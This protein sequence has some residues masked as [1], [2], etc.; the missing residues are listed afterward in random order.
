MV[1]AENLV[2]L[3][4]TTLV[5]MQDSSLTC[6]SCELITFDL[7][8]LE[9]VALMPMKLSNLC[10]RLDNFLRPSMVYGTTRSTG[11]DTCLICDCDQLIQS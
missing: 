2:E 6:T 4:G 1:A 10:N 7:K 5:R 11:G 9:S 8:H 3:P